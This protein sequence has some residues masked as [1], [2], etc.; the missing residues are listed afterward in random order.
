MEPK[1]I[2]IEMQ[3]ND[4]GVVGTLVWP[5]DTR[6]QAESKLHSVLAAAAISELPLHAASLLQSDGRLLDC[7]SYEHGEPEP[8]PQP[9]PEDGE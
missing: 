1:Y 9:E 3:T 7:R 5:F 2:V 8:E 6:N 4:S